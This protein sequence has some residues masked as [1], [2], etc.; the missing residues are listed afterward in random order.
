MHT[1]RL[2]R[3][4]C[5]ALFPCMAVHAQ[6]SPL[7]NPAT[8]EV[9]LPAPPGWNASLVYASPYGIWTVRC[10][11]VFP[12]L[13][14]PELV[15]L[16]DFGRCTVLVSYSGKWTPNQTVEDRAWLGA[17]AHVDLDD[18]IPGPELYTG[19]KNGNLYQIV[20]HE[21]MGFDTRILARVRALELH[22]FVSGDLLADRPG[23]EML[24]FALSGE[25]FDLRMH[26]GQATFP[27]I[28]KLPG[29]VR[30]AVVLDRSD[31]EGDPWIAT[32]MRAKRVA[33]VRHRGETIESKVILEEPMGFG[34]IARRSWRPGSP[35]VLY[36]TRDDGVVL[37][38][39]ER[40]DGT[41][42]REMIYAG[43]Q[44]LRGIVSG[45]FD[46][47]PEAETVAVFGY[48]KKVQLLTRLPG[49]PW[50]VETIFTEIDKGH[51]LEVAELDG[52]NATQEIVGSGYGA[53][54]FLLSRPPG[55][56]LDAVPTD[57]GK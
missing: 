10:F 15:G 14:S 23:C 32:V 51:W 55:Y 53:R 38:L 45:R 39:E 33:L 37:R 40:P 43:P 52:R 48:S 5:L 20:A 49:K 24:A 25:V 2:L 8:E 50:R 30:D 21:E 42:Q 1:T 9:P 7:P 22:T 54:I 34:R 31:R 46:A 56:G 44:G 57:P 27:Q 47:N 26:G 35:D 19:G 13:G 28:A 17:I 12:H 36:V 11:D 6:E 16:D 18:T 41:W 3:T 29:R 4:L